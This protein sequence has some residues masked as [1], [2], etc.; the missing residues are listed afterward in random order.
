[1]NTETIP[2]L[3]LHIKLAF[4]L[5]QAAEGIKTSCFSMFLLLFYN[6]VLGVSGTLCGI[7]LALSLLSDAITD[8]IV[9]SLSDASRSK[10]GRRHPFMYVTAIPLGIFFYLLF[11]PL[12]T[13]E[14]PLFFWLLTFTVCSRAAMTFYAVPHLTLG[15]ELSNDFHERTALSALRQF[16]GACAFIG[17]FALGFGV[18]FSPTEDYPNGQLNPSAYPPLTAWLSVIITLVVLLSAYG[19]RKRIPYL[20]KASANQHFTLASVFGDTLKTMSNVSFRSVMIGFTIITAA[21]G[22]AGSLMM[23]MLTFFWQLNAAG[24]FIVLVAGPIGGMIAYST[25]K[26]FFNLFDKKNGVIIGGSIWLAIQISVVPAYMVGWLPELGSQNLLVVI[27]ISQIVGAFGMGQ[28][29]V[30]LGTMVADIADEHEL[31]T[32]ERREGIFY[33]AF[34]FL[35][36]TSV[37]LG[38]LISGFIL[39]LLNW[40]AGEAVRAAA[41]IPAETIQNLGIAWGPLAGVFALPALLIMTSYSLN[42][43]RHNEILQLLSERQAKSAAN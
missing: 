23:Y 8:P 17:V 16:F 11:N 13:G 14:W 21:L 1:M 39:E 15:A 24:I 35:H 25:S 38:T 43:Q 41:D 18:Y 2:A 4:G 27:A 3:S 22:T 6:Q 31:H 36:K 26:A 33:G 40:P 10:R 7:A 5:G 37:A 42:R 32:S 30:G 9:G 12:V 28:V 20:P 29:L 19:T 34:S